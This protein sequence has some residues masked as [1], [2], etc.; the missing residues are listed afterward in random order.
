MSDFAIFQDFIAKEDARQL[1]NILDANK[2]PFTVVENAYEVDITF[3]GNIPRNF[4]VF[5]HPSNF[6]RV[7]QILD[8]DAENQLDNVDPN[9]YLYDFAKS[10]LY[11]VITKKD[12]WSAYDYQLAKKILIERGESIDPEA[13]AIYQEQRLQELSQPAEKPTVYLILGAIFA[14]LG[15]VVGFMIGWYLY[16]AKKTLPN[17]TKMYTYANEDRKLALNIFLV[18]IV[19]SGAWWYIYLKTI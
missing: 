13:I 16:S 4:Q 1:L 8:K 15:G 6:E 2:I 19:I 9:H 12:E 14:L 5:V 11:E 3:G 18:G 17:G 7:H 10:E